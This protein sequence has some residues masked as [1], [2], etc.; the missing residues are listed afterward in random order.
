MGDEKPEDLILTSEDDGIKLPR[1]LHLIPARWNVENSDEALAAR[2]KF[3]NR[4]DV[5]IDPLTRLRGKYDL[6]S[7][8][9]PPTRRRPPLPHTRQPTGLSCRRCQRPSRLRASMML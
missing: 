4:P 9:R 7:W 8:I 3:L 5:L 2:D 1:N 6:S